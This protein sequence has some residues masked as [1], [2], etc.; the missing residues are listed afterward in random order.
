ML[1]TEPRHQHPSKED[2]IRQGDAIKPRGA[3]RREV[4]MEGMEDDTLKAYR[5]IHKDSHKTP[6]H[7]RLQ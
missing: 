7:I 4:E 5:V 3:H 1:G 6:R 2:E